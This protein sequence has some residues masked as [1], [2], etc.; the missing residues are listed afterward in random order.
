M[1]AKPDPGMSKQAS[2]ALDKLAKRFKVTREQ[3]IERLILSGAPAQPQ[4]N[5]NAPGD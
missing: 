1:A 2:A 3:M 5:T 4:E